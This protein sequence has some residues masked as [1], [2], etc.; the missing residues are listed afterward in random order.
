M[1]A[2]FLQLADKTILVCGVANKKS[3]AWHTAKILRDAGATVVYSVRTAARRE[4]LLALVPEADVYVCDVERQH[5][6]DR[7]AV[8][9]VQKHPVLDGLLHSIAFADYADGPKP[10]HETERGAFLR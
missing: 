7:L 2:D 6:I 4:Q 10:F 8:D 1:V 3:V 5:E 9:V